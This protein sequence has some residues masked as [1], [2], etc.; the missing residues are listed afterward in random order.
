MAKIKLTVAHELVD[1]EVLVFKAPCNCIDVDG[2]VV[3]Y[4]VLTESNAKE[5]SKTFVFKDSHGNTLT[6]LG[7]LFNAGAYVSVIL[8]TTDGYAY[9][10][11]AATNKY[12]ESKIVYSET[13]PTNPFVG[14]IWLQP[15]AMEEI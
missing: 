11:N 7:N 15:I 14:Q 6:G 2:I 13:E 12:L 10:Q 8:N 5:E 4:T 3:Y 9:I 1:G